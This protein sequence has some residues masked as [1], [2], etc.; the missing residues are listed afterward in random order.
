MCTSDDLTQKIVR[1]GRSA[2]TRGG[3]VALTLI[4]IPP[5]EGADVAPGRG[6]ATVRLV[7][8]G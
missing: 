1:I 6:L 5:F 8:I 3:S 2:I 4:R 7:R